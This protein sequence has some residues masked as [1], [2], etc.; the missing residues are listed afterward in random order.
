VKDARGVE[1]CSVFYID[2]T[3]GITSSARVG[4]G[5]RGRGVGLGKRIRQGW[6]SCEG[7]DSALTNCVNAM[8]KAWKALRGALKS[9]WNLSSLTFP[10]WHTTSERSVGETS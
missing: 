7:Q 1:I 8:E 6:R 3:L 4:T 5:K 9:R 2:C 10:N